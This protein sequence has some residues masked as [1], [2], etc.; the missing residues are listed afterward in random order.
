MRRW[1]TEL[2]PVFGPRGGRP[3]VR[4]SVKRCGVRRQLLVGGGVVAVNRAT[5]ATT[6][7]ALIAAAS[8][9][10]GLAA[11]AGPS[12]TEP[13]KGPVRLVVPF[14]PGGIADL[15]ARAVARGLETVLATSVIVE[16]KPGAGGV[17]AGLQV[18]KALPDGRTLLLVSNGTAVSQALFRS[19]PFDALKDFS[20]IGS[21]AAFPIAITV[22]ADAPHRTLGDFVAEA[23]LRPGRLTVG[24]IAIGS[25][26][27]LSAE[28]FR[29]VAGVDFTVV[30]FN[31][32][33]NLITA[34]RAGDVDAGFEILGP[35]L[36]QVSGRA[37]RLL[38]VSSARRSPA[39]PDV[40][41]VAEAGVG[42]D[43]YDVVSWNGLAAPAATPPVLIDRLAKAIT[44]ALGDA[45]VTGPLARSGI[46]PLV[47]SPALLQRRLAD[48][49]VRWRTVID[50][51]GIER[52]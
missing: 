2:R 4:S 22:R 43:G 30:P 23:K 35:L 40:P 46:E 6:V 44:T 42:A 9:R 5:A 14:G 49:V 51:A 39:C 34:I 52:Q 25:T 18:V 31:G 16:N 28:L 41:T 37:L 11:T 10:P 47:E 36:P 45:E 26:Q 21:L 13:F 27:H 19:L 8:I 50:R 38:A 17:V 7:S 48:E 12:A 24:T 20:P 33:P 1:W 3:R 32:T 29:T 15:T